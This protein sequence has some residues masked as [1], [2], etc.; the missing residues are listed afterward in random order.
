VDLDLGQ[1][2]LGPP[3]ALGLGLFPPRYPGDEPLFPEALHFIGQTSP[4]G[5]SLEVAVGCRVLS[6]RAA[7]AGDAWI[8]VN[9]SGYVHG[10]GAW[11]L[12]RA[13]LELLQPRL[14]LALERAG[15]LA[16]LLADLTAGDASWGLSLPVAARARPKTPETRRRYREARFGLYFAC[17]RALT[18][19]RSQ[20]R[21]QG[22]P[23]GRGAPLSPGDLARY[24][25]RLQTAVLYGE[26][27]AR[28]TLLLVQEPVAAPPSG[29]DGPVLTCISWPALHLRLIGLLDGRRHTLALG[30]L[31]P[32]AWSEGRITVFTPLPPHL[33]EQ[34]RFLSVGRLRLS[35]EG[36]ELPETPVPETHARPGG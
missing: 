15:E 20:I 23:W 26:A 13:E 24:R 25:D 2:H 32:S 3:A 6:D 34:V 30:L 22:L 4:V 33:K 28:R 16:A 21:W 19:F 1:S 9:T 11:R 27:H 36:R 7:A 14:V 29:A 8:V 10:P 31:L 5:A 12:K 35:P 17:A 18:L